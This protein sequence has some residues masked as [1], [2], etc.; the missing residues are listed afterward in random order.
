MVVLHMLTQQIILN[1]LSKKISFFQANYGV[2]RIGLFGSYSRDEQ[3]D[4][5][6]VDIVVEFHKNKLTFDNYMDLKCYL[7][8]QFGRSVDLVILD[9]IKPELKSSI[10]RSTIYAE[11]A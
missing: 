6:D 4:D 10:L 5:S 11:G 1:E 3:T 9:D 8:D 7:E 2:N